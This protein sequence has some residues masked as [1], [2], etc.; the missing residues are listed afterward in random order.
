MLSKEK[1]TESEKVHRSL[2]DKRQAE[3]LKAVIAKIE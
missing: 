2:R 1:M 3:R